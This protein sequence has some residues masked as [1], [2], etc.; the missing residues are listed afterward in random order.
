MSER[1]AAKKRP[2]T[3]ADVEALP[4]HKLGEIIGDELFVSP[5]PA[6][7]HALATTSLVGALDGPF[8]R[9][10]NGPGG[11]WI[12][13]EPEFHWGRQV[14][15]PDIAGWRRERMPELPQTAFFTVPPDWLCETLSPSTAV[16]DRTRKLDVYAGQG[17]DWVWLVDPAARTLE[18]LRRDGTRWTVAENHGG[19]AKV[20]AAPFEAI[21]LALADLWLPEPR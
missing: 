19:D 3:Y 14:L 2:A 21:E 9:G 11:W 4:E 1:G 10:Q 5:R 13:F 15:V 20:R 8:G 7:L 17:V 18:V 6:P 12:L 16:V